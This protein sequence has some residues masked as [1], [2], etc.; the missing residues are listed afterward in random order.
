M[1]RALVTGARG[2]IG[3]RC[4]AGL[5]RSGYAVHAVSARPISEVGSGSTVRWHHADL[6]DPRQAAAVIDRVKPTHLLHLA[7]YVEPGRFWTSTENFRWVEATLTL[8]R[9]FV[10]AGG[11]RF[12]GAGTCAEYD[13]TTGAEWYTEDMDDRATTP[14]GVAKKATADL[15]AVHAQLASVSFGWGRVFHLYGPAEDERRVT[16]SVIR[17]LLRGER[18]RCSDGT[19]VRDFMHV[20]DVADAFVALLGTEV[21]GL[22]NVA[23]GIPVTVRAVIEQIA[24]SLQSEYL[25]D[26]GVIPQRPG[27]PPRIV[28]DVRR[29]AREVGFHPSYTLPNGLDDT[30]DWWRHH[31]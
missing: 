28:A 18:A 29:L 23:S 21:T 24:R 20:Q 30:I 19:Q 26:L 8:F 5:A 7:W 2:F 15:L 17:S 1:N 27:E 6:L 11:R 9:E 31:A 13:W 14:Y 3:S 4:L 25:V 16:A 10:A 22:V 12:V